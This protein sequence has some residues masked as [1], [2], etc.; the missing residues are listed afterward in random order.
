MLKVEAYS[1][2]ATAI[3]DWIWLVATPVTGG[4][5]AALSPLLVG[6]GVAL[7]AGWLLPGLP[8]AVAIGAGIAVVVAGFAVGPAVLRVYG[9][10]TGELL[11]PAHRSWWRRSGFGPWLGRAMKRTWNG[12]GLAGMALGALGLLALQL[13]FAVVSWG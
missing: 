4:L 7:A 11:Q 12:A 10:W 1:K 9:L 5:A 8:T 6:A 13:V 3:R 2:D